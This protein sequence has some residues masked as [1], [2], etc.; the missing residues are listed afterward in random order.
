MSHDYRMVTPDEMADIIASCRAT[1]ADVASVIIQ[2]LDAGEDINAI[3]AKVT[4][5]ESQAS[6]QAVPVI[7]AQE[8]FFHLVTRLVVAQIMI[9]EMRRGN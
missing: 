6:V 2:E 5:A 3:M 4:L 9:A 1:A 8:V 7:G